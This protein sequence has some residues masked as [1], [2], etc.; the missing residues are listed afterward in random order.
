[1]EEIYGAASSCYWAA[2]DDPNS[3]QISSAVFASR[4]HDSPCRRCPVMSAHISDSLSSSYS[5]DTGSSWRKR[6]GRR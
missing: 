4:T 6:L 5:S 2:S 3:S 1:M